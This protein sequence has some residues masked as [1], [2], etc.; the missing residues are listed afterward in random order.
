MEYGGTPM[1]RVYVRIHRGCNYVIVLRGLNVRSSR[2]LD[3]CGYRIYVVHVLVI[4]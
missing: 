2:W 3:P 1:L 4:L